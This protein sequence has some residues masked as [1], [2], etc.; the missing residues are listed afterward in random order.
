MHRSA[1]CSEASGASFFYGCG[2]TVARSLFGENMPDKKTAPNEEVAGKTVRRAESDGH[3]EL[4]IWVNAR[5]DEVQTCRLIAASNTVVLKDNERDET[6]ELIET[7]GNTLTARGGFGQDHLPTHGRILSL[8][9]CSRD[10]PDNVH[11]G[12]SKRTVFLTRRSG[13]HKSDG[14]FSWKEQFQQT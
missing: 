3:R 4:L 12:F 2:V 9:P 5:T 8:V 10:T 13:K 1:F 11:P 14:A 6:S 7:C